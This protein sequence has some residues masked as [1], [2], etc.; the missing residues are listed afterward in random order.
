MSGSKAL[1]GNYEADY[2]TKGQTNCANSTWTTLIYLAGYGPGLFQVNATVNGNYSAYGATMLVNIGYGNDW[3][4]AIKYPTAAIAASNTGFRVSGSE[5]QYI[6]YAGST[7]AVMWKISR[8][9]ETNSSVT[10]TT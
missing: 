7:Q 8:I 1:S 5:V 2:A 10:G 3:G 4:T 6:Q 9:M